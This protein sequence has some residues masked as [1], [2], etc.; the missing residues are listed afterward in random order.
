MLK[1]KYIE[2][3]YTL[4]NQN[5][6]SSIMQIIEGDILT[7]FPSILKTAIEELKLMDL[8]NHSKLFLKNND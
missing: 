2:A 7:G 3:V 5:Y 1:E 8:N 4:P 6:S